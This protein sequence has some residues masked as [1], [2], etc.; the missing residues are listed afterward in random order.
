MTD[1][2]QPNKRRGRGR[3][4]VYAGP[5]KRQNFSFRLTPKLR[6]RLM[7]AVKKSGRSLSMEVEFRVNQ[8]FELEAALGEAEQF[9]AYLA[10][11]KARAEQAEKEMLQVHLHRQGWAKTRNLV[12]GEIVWSPPETHN[13]PPS[14]FEPSD[15]P[16][17]PT[18][19]PPVLREAVREEVQAAV[20]ELLRE[21]GLLK[22]PG[23][24]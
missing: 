3:P 13:V 1:T 20:R 16:P 10:E 18:T 15:A 5:G 12:T 21:A 17:A 11:S 19:L 9:R 23:A 7:E 22:K 4:P 8:A 6:E 2:D 24:A 14:G